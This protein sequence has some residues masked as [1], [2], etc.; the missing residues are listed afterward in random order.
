MVIYR[1]WKHIDGRRDIA[2]RGAIEAL[3]LE[4]SG[5]R[6]KQQLSAVVLA[7]G[8]LG[9]GDNHR[10]SLSLNKHLFG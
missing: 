8:S 3:F 2:N 10:G 1:A 6:I 7:N 5:G 4:C 9:F